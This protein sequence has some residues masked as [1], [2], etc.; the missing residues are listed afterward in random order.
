M[1]YDS[2][3]Q[4]IG[5]TPI[6]NLKRFCQFKGA[7][8]EIFVKL[9][10]FNPG[11]SAKDRVALRMIERAEQE[12]TLKP[13]GTVIEP[14]SGNTGVGLAAITAA[15]GYRLI[16]TMP[17]N[18]SVER[19]KLARAYGATVVLT[20]AVEGMA[21]AIK[22]AE[23]I[24]Q[25]TPN[26]MIAGQFVNPANPEAHYLTTGP[27]IFRDCKGI[28][29]YFVAA[30][31]TG[32][33]LTGAGE[34]LKDKIKKLKIVAVEPESSAVLSGKP[35]GP[36]KIQGIGAGF[37]PEVLNKKLINEIIPVSDSDAFNTQKDLVRSEGIL[38]GI[39]SGAALYA[40]LQ[41]AL[42]PENEGKRILAVLC[43]T[44]ERYLSTEGFI[45]D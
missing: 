36:H 17:D 9:E 21:G 42:R 1:V 24:A 43:D 23:R 12:G 10:R 5:N 2:L 7:N 44:G 14:T 13:G 3:E 32:G 34:Y 29:D 40:A 38:T 22:E 33:T 18:M 4:L 45:E 19:V 8:A 37:V 20:P 27:E 31:G 30:V 25:E 6:L 28:L 11:G 41:L 16:L 15:K 26:G 35:K 39:S